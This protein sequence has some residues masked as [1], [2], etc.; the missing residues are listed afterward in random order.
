MFKV[1]MVSL[2]EID[3]KTFIVYFLQQVVNLMI[4]VKEII[5]NFVSLLV[6]QQILKTMPLWWVW[7]MTNVMSLDIV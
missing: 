5:L 4:T 6:S 7:N 1:I 3:H 2:M